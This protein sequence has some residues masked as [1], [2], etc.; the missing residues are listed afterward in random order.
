MSF[1]CIV[2]GFSVPTVLDRELSVHGKLVLGGVNVPNTQNL[3]NPRK[4]KNNLILKRC[5]CL[6]QTF[7]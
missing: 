3:N 7:H 1:A 6:K 5:K 4:E 2:V